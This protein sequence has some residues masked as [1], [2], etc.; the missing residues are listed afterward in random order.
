MPCFNPLGAYRTENLNGERL[1]RNG[2]NPVYFLKKGQQPPGRCSLLDTFELPCT[3]CIG[4]QLK[5]ASDWATRCMHEYENHDEGCF[6]TLTYDRDNLITAV[7]PNSLPTLYKPDLQRFWKR[8]RQHIARKEKRSV[9]IKY[10]ACGEYGPTTG[11]PHYHAVLFGWQ[12]NDETAIPNNPGT[13][14]PVFISETVNQ[15]WTH[16]RVIIGSLTKASANYVARYCLKKLYGEA[17]LN[18]YR[19]TNREAPFNCMSKG[20]GA[21]FFEKYSGDFYP[22][23]FLVDSEDYIRKTIPRYYDKLLA[24]IDE[25]FLWEIKN[26]RIARIEKRKRTHPREFT[27]ER[28]NVREQVIKLRVAR[29]TRAYEQTASGASGGKNFFPPNCINLQQTVSPCN[30]KTVQTQAQGLLF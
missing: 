27:P 15:L 7:Y 21:D 4:C 20:I 3:K 23:D 8:L 19:N 30:N 6:L 1:T 22:S 5:R 16:G 10:F 12:P 18:E 2:K 11:R 24:K 28:R 25:E 9:D 13:T 29:L 14:N 26:A 17:A